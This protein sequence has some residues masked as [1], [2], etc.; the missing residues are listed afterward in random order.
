MRRSWL[1]VCA[2]AE[3][4]KREGRRQKA[5]GRKNLRIILVSSALRISY[6]DHTRRHMNIS[7]QA[8]S[9]LPSAFCLLPSA[10]CLLPSAFCLLPS[11]FCLLPSAFCLL[12]SSHISV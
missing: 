6:Q 5:E 10:F 11:A 8:S 1:V 12:P 7:S 3:T 9:L 2:D 4:Q